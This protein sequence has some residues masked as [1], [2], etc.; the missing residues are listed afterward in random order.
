M[1]YILGPG[2]LVLGSGV[3]GPASWV[4]GSACWVLVLH[5]RS[6]VL[7]VVSWSCILDPGSQVLCPAISAHPSL[8]LTCLSLLPLPTAGQ[9]LR[10]T[11]LA[12]SP[13]R[14][15]LGPPEGCRGQH[16]APSH[17]IT[18]GARFVAHRRSVGKTRIHN[19]FLFLEEAGL[20]L[21]FWPD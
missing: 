12:L 7:D 5:P 18:Q 20:L 8:P 14:I 4:L 10:C 9:W 21:G 2:C 11:L 13:S 19:L 16:P 17:V 3:S 15:V 1:S 6:S